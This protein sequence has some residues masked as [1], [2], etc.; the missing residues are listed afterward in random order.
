M[1]PTPGN[2]LVDELPEDIRADVGRL[3]PEEQQLFFAALVDPKTLGLLYSVDYTEVPVPPEVFFSS[4]YYFGKDMVW[5]PK[6]HRGLFPVWFDELCYVLNPDNRINEFILSGSLGSGK[7]T[8]AMSALM[9]QIYK[10]SCLRD[11]HAYLGMLPS[12][13]IEI[14]MFSVT[15]TTVEDA[16]VARF[17]RLLGQSPYFR[18]KFPITRRRRFRGRH[19][20][21][22]YDFKLEMP[23]FLEIVQGSQETHFISRDILGGMLDEANFVKQA[24]G[25]GALNYDST[26]KV[27]NLYQSLRN[28]IES[29][30]MKQG[31]NLGLMCLI[32]SA[33][34]RFDFLEQ[35]KRRQ[36]D[37]PHVRIAEYPLY[38]VKPWEYAGKKFRVLIGTEHSNSRI[39][40][41]GEQPDMSVSTQIIE[42]PSEHEDAFKRDISRALRE[43]SGVPSEVISPFIQRDYIGRSV[44]TVRRHPFKVE[45]PSISHLSPIP[46]ETYL[47]SQDLARWAGSRLVP[48]HHQAAARYIHCDLSKNQCATG[49]TMGCVCGWQETSNMG[50]DGYPVVSRSPLIW[51]DFTLQILPPEAPGE[52]DY[53]KVR[54]FIRYLRDSLHFPVAK[55]SFDGFNS[56]DMIQI[57]L[58]ENFD[59]EV[60]SMD[61]TPGPYLALRAALMENRVLRPPYPPLDTELA[62]LRMIVEGGKVWFER[63][64]GEF[65]DVADSIAGVVFWCQEESDMG[66]TPPP[67]GPPSQTKSEAMLPWLSG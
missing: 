25:T 3:S 30:F 56:I 59:A 29:R 6:E 17:E 39:L 23:P 55:V 36:R 62:T 1:E 64:A 26:S 22:P 45:S 41:E 67:P 18:K 7:T 21:D 46:L 13:P 35:H 2:P 37:D 49:L 57:L 19:G 33:A 51:V 5:D 66:R 54:A 44:D 63:G 34:T 15:M 4:P 38:D 48:K 27:F 50:P 60:L 28:R 40:A 9:Y 14:F 52:I 65:K 16:G 58:K 8:C 20:S 61:K 32:S 24:K 10:L 43:I 42:V 11:P 53:S 31:Q 12:A 47:Q